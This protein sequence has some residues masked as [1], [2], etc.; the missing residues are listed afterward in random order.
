MSKININV[1]Q[2]EF[3]IGRLIANLKS[4]KTSISP[5][6]L[7]GLPYP[8]GNALGLINQVAPPRD[9]IGEAAQAVLNGQ[10]PDPILALANAGDLRPKVGEV[11]ARDANR[12]YVDALNA[13]AAA[14]IR[15]LRAEAFEP[16]I[17]AL[18]I[19]HD[20]H[21]A[22]ADLNAAVKAENFD[23]AAAI[24]A[25]EDSIGE[26]MTLHEA[27]QLLH[28]SEGPRG[29]ENLF[30]DSAAWVREPG[31]FDEVGDASK[32]DERKV[33]NMHRLQWWLDL[34]EAGY[35][36]HYPTYAEWQELRTSQEF[37][38]YQL[39]HDEPEEPV[40]AAGVKMTAS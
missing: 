19:F 33:P 28:S 6:L 2:T 3:Q 34:L 31:A 8:N 29:G 25:A 40:F 18:T 1:Q 17:E 5:E 32:L 4:R 21:G 23:L 37:T 16:I 14:I 27:R 22:Q 9:Y 35:T 30:M 26:V 15:T 11:L 38:N 39:T 12:K 20:E 7:A 10:D 13:N 24:R 36:P